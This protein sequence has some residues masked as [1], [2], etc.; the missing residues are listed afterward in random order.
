MTRSLSQAA[1]LPCPQCGQLIAAEVWIVVDVEE[2]PDLA[3]LA[4][5]GR[6]HDVQCPN[7]GAQNSIEAPLLYHDS[8]V[9][10]LIYAAP[11]Q[12]SIDEDRQI[13]THLAQHLLA[14]IEDQ[15]PPYLQKVEIVP[16]LESLGP[17][18]EQP[19]IV[20]AQEPPSE[21]AA[22]LAIA[23]LLSADSESAFEIAVDMHPA[24]LHPSIDELLEIM[25][26]EAQA[27]HDSAFAGSL[28][29]V[30]ERLSATRVTRTHSLAL[31]ATIHEL[32]AADSE[33][34]AAAVV[35]EHATYLLSPEAGDVLSELAKAAEREG[36]EALAGRLRDVRDALH[37]L[38]NGGQNS[39]QN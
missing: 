30:R 22:R 11:D 31:L 3:V 37:T 38:R 14:G 21:A 8:V 25:I 16:G 39:E 5:D 24:A 2:R 36:D 6:L 13:A 27:N 17:A 4:C 29:F 34:E 33:E 26:G 32:L 12:T 1:E 20:D 9:R 28:R 18:L 35:E 7:C 15:S 10:R 19:P 23:A